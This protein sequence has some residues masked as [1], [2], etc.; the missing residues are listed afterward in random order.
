VRDSLPAVA[1]RRHRLVASGIVQGPYDTQ[2]SLIL[3]LRSSLPFSPT[4][5]LD[6]NFDGYTQDLP[7]GVVRGS[8]CRTLDLDAVN[9]WRASRNLPAVGEPACPGFANLD[10]RVSKF[11]TV[12]PG[13]RFEVIAQLFNVF[14]RANF[15]I[16]ANNMGA[17]NFGQVNS[18]L[19]NINAPSRQVELAVRYQF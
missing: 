3:D 18:I 8:G 5:S 11:F 16:P 19:P 17:G 9:A 15:N 7:A 2:L 10:V 1:D 13:H 12:I 6:L 4:T 14:N